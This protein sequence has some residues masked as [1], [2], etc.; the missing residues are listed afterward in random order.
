[1][2]D[3]TR[4]LTG[5]SRRPDPKRMLAKNRTAPVEE[6]PAEEPAAAE[7]TVAVEVE[8]QPEAA[9]P[10]KPRTSSTRSTSTASAAR[11]DAGYLEYERKEARFREGVVSE[12]TAHARRLNRMKTDKAAPR[13]TENS[14]IR[15]AVDLL[16]SKVDDLHGNTEEEL[17]NSVSL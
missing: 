1:M 8:K 17:R 3:T 13:I 2:S 12:L 7:A 15:V 16:L 4:G 11:E 10:P 14:L 9:R 6:V 5:V